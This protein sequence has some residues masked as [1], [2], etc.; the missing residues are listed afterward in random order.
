MLHLRYK[1]RRNCQDARKHDNLTQQITILQSINTKEK[2]DMPEYLQYRDCGFMYSPHTKFIDFFRQVDS[3]VKE[4]T[5]D[6]CF[7]EHGDELV[8]VR[9]IVTDK[10]ILIFVIP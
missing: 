7:K 6:S 3:C 5:N 9:I 8:K 10:V 4:V 2:L 1:Q